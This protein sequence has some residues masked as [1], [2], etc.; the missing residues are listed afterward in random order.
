MGIRGIIRRPI[1]LENMSVQLLDLLI[2]PA[3]AQQGGPQDM[4]AVLRFLNSGGI[5]L[6]F[7]P[8][9][10]FMMIRPQMRRSRETR[11]MLSKLAKGDEIVIS[12]GLAG[13]IAGIGEV[14][15][16][17]EIA[18]GVEVKVQKTAVGSV[19]PKGTLKTL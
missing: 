2:A 13:R 6:I 12:G 10:Y 18:P 19:L 17:V 7:I 5:F 8:L 14:Y 11:D 3:Y 15:L 4:P 16:T 1:D 9:L